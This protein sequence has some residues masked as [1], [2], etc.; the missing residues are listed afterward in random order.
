MASRLGNR[1]TEVA[2]VSVARLFYTIH[3]VKCKA[4]PVLD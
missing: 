3:K 2:T 4:D 1:W